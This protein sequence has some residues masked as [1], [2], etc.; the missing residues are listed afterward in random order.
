MYCL[1]L[2]QPDLSF[3]TTALALTSTGGCR[4]RPSTRDAL[5]LWSSCASH[6][7]LLALLPLEF[8]ADS[9]YAA[10]TTSQQAGP[11]RIPNT[12]PMS[13]TRPLLQH[14]ACAI[15]WSS[16][17]GGGALHCCLQP[18]YTGIIAVRRYKYYKNHVKQCFLL[19]LLSM[20]SRRASDQTKYQ[21]VLLLSLIMCMYHTLT[22]SLSNNE[23][24]VP[25]RCK[26]LTTA[27]AATLVQEYIL[28]AYDNVL[29]HVPCMIG[30]ACQAMQHLCCLTLHQL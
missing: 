30:R 21:E 3:L 26:L 29:R 19:V 22:L 23:G 6:S 5:R 8:A 9:R 12:N 7:A 18:A 27:L 11:T 2:E 14:M 1:L 24:C 4:C 20:H 13:E 28:K 25:W 16:L 10:N 15:V 17:P